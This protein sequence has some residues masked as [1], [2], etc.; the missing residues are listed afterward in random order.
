MDNY[1][2]IKYSMVLIFYFD[3]IFIEEMKKKFIYSDILRHKRIVGNIYIYCTV[4]TVC[5]CEPTIEE[6]K[7]CIILLKSISPNTCFTP[8]MKK[9]THFICAKLSISE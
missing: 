2:D 4:Y 5:D 1:N 9:L 6:N 8:I 3:D 7:G